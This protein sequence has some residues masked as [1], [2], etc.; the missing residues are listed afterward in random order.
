MCLV[1]VG[2]TVS[3]CVC[4]IGQEVTP[5]CLLRCRRGETHTADQ[6]PQLSLVSSAAGVKGQIGEQAGWLMVEERVR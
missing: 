3:V 4:H 2:V 6:L 5:R 1:Y